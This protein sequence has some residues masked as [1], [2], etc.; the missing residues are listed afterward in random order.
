MPSTST[1][2]RARAPTVGPVGDAALRAAVTADLLEV[3]DH[4]RSVH[5]SGA[6]GCAPGFA[7]VPLA[8]AGEMGPDHPALHHAALPVDRVRRDVSG[9]VLR[10]PVH[11]SIP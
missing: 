2:G 10:D 8:V 1:S 7:P 5:L 4:D 9:G 3:M 6:R 11:R